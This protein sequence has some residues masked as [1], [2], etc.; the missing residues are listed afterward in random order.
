MSLTINSRLC[1][2]PIGRPP[3]IRVSQYDS[4]F[5]I[6]FEMYTIES[7]E[8]DLEA[9]TTA[10]IR[11]TKTD[12]RGYSADCDIDIEHK[13]VT[14]YGDIQMTAAAGPCVY[15]IVLMKGT[16]ELGSINFTL[17]VER[18]ALDADT[19]PSES[20][21][22]EIQ[23]IGQKADEII[24]AYEN[25]QFDTTPTAGSTKAVTSGGIYNALTSIKSISCAD[26]NSDG[27]IVITFTSYGE[28]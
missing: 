7:I 1:I 10:K 14:V 19:I 22:K 15:E 5:E 4:D 9:G 2:A 23:E 6:L 17:Q 24:E 13:L 3:V 11:G 21:I 20:Q 18:A 12:K 16:K 26:T 25:L 27:N 8:W 28:E